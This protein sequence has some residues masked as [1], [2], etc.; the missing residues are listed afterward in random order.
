M[1]ITDREENI[2]S[3]EVDQRRI[4]LLTR[5][6]LALIMA[7][8]RGS[9]LKELTQ[10][11]VKPAVYFGGKFRII[12][13]PLSNCV[14]S[15]IRRIGVVTQYK[16]H[17]LIR[18]INR[19]WTN[20]KSE[21]GEFVDILPASQRKSEQWYAGTA[22]SIYQN[23]DIIDVY[24]PK[25][26][27][28]LAGD[29]VYKMDYGLMVAAHVKSGAGVTVGCIE[30]PVQDAKEYGVMTV[31]ENMQVI[32]FHEKPENPET[33]PGRSDQALASMGIYVFDKDFLFSELEKNAADPDT[34]HDFGKDIVP[35]LVEQGKAFAYSF[36][37]PITG[38]QGYWRDVGT[39]DSFWKA[40]IELADYEPQL[41]M[42]DDKWPIWT[43]Q[44]QLPPA[45]FVHRDPDRRGLALQSLI[46]GGCIVSGSEVDGSVLFSNVRVNSHSSIIDSVI[47]P[48]VEIGRHCQIKRTIIDRACRIPEGMK[49]G[50]DLDEDRKRFNVT[51]NG[52]VLVTASMLGQR[53]VLDN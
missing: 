42:Y 32:R 2:M 31:D 13:F 5:D 12:D 30:V 18:H 44:A 19:G 14:N 23:L 20:F 46:S 33:L 10:W 51:D 25:Y 45:K 3:S 22:D 37:D 43:Y 1:Y 40:N 11:R 41:N 9:R 38:T 39:V 53:Q 6:T 29:H 16:A 27:L 49:I 36:R 17:S 52:I 50:Y 26:I 34:H 28:I 21:L 47:L 8:G 24:N 48:Q 15:G 7:G 4:S 35:K